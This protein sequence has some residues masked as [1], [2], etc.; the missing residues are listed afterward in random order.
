M[1]ALLYFNAPKFWS[2]FYNSKFVFIVGNLIVVA[3]IGESKIFSYSSPGATD[4]YYEQYVSSSRKLQQ[5]LAPQA[6]KDIVL[7]KMTWEEERVEVD[8]KELKGLDGEVDDDELSLP[9]EEL[10]KRADDYIA[11]VNKHRILEATQLLCDGENRVT[12]PDKY[13]RARR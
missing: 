4:D 3:L 10:N 2:I 12:K 1:K 7:K 6:M 8:Q 11:K 13:E 5:S 9:T